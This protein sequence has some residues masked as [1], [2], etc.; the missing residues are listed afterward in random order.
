[1]VW[2][3]DVNF[4]VDWVDSHFMPIPLDPQPEP[5]TRISQLAAHNPQPEPRSL[6]HQI[7]HRLLQA[8]QGELKHGKD[9]ADGANGAGVVP[10]GCRHGI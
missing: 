3:G 6:R 2:F 10:H 9:L 5:V 8:V 4:W 1:M 7:R